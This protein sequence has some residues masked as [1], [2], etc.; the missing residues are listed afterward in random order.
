MINF[1]EL[2]C[3]TTSNKTLV[4]ISNYCYISDTEDS[5]AFYYCYDGNDFLT[6]RVKEDYET[7]KRK[8][9]NAIAFS[10]VDYEDR[11]VDLFFF[12]RLIYLFRLRLKT[13][14]TSFVYKRVNSPCFMVSV[15]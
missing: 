6:L 8:I 4:N 7:V 3:A 12:S 10:K 9:E 11:L 15:D 14:V 5:T 1:I 2:T 13:A